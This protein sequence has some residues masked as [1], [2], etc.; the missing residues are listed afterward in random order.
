M[1]KKRCYY[2]GKLF[3]SDPRVG[4]RQK[5]C[6]AALPVGRQVLLVGR[7]VVRDKGRGRTI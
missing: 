7:Q 2:Y 3:I 5:T 4:N 6:S 1:A